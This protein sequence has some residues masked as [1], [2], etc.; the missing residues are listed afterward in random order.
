MG[1]ACSYIEGDDRDRSAGVGN[2]AMPSAETFAASRRPAWIKALPLA[3]LRGCLGAAISRASSK[4]PDGRL[5]PTMV[6]THVVARDQM[7]P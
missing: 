4:R 3:L 6:A 2:A 5:I 1:S 7:W